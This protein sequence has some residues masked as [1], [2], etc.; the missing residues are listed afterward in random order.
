[1]QKEAR[2]WLA[3][4][5]SLL[6]RS[7]ELEKAILYLNISL[8]LSDPDREKELRYEAY[9]SLAETYFKLRW[10][11]ECLEAGEKCFRLKPEKSEV[12]V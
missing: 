7:R 5:S 10:Y 12:K 8:E 4:G 1:M 2:Y 6:K 9:F 11:D 3:L